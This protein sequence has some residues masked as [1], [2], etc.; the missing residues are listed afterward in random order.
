MILLLLL[1]LLPF[2]A[3]LVAQGAIV[4]LNKLLTVISS[5]P[6]VPELR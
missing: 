4:T 6:Q 1:L 2:T 5:A 3:K